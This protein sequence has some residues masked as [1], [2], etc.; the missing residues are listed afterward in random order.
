[1][2]ILLEISH[3]NGII[4]SQMWVQ[5][6]HMNPLCTCRSCRSVP[7]IINKEISLYKDDYII[8]FFFIG[9][10]YGTQMGPFWATRIWA[11]P[12][13]AHAKTGCTP[14]MDSPYGYPIW[15][16]YRHVC[17]ELTEMWFG[18][19]TLLFKTNLIH[20]L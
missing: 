8:S 7:C 12:Y 5:A 20:S 16:P 4:L 6:N 1:M 9:L 3:K 2:L 18:A 17:L 13:G 14:H 10:Q 11:N 19:Y 15:D